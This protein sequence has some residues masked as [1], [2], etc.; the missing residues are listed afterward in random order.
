MYIFSVWGLPEK[1]PRTPAEEDAYYAQ[2]E[3]WPGVAAISAVRR[4]FERI[5]S[6]RRVTATGNQLCSRDCR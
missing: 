4:W 5:F 6:N 3:A 2:F 1:P